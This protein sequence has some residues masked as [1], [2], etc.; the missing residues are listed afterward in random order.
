M[1]EGEKTVPTEESNNVHIYIILVIVIFVASVFIW[2]Y[3]RDE[4]LKEN[5]EYTNAIIHEITSCDKTRGRRCIGYNY[6]VDGTKYKSMEGWYPNG[7]TFSVGDTIII[8]YNK[9]NPAH[10]STKRYMELKWWRQ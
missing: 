8:I 10:N 3:N 4:T 7:D 2:Q 5:G 6:I 1:K 9:K